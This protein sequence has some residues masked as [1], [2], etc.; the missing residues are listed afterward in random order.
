M[1]GEKESANRARGRRDSVKQPAPGVWLLPAHHLTIRPDTAGHFALTRF[2]QPAY[3]TACVL[4]RWMLRQQVEGNGS[5]PD[6]STKRSESLL[7]LGAVF[8][9]LTYS[10]PDQRYQPVRAKWKLRSQ[11]LSSELLFSS[12]GTEL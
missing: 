9:R 11:P 6:S 7:S 4:F 10:H 3:S 5:C 2:V 8:T 12:W 1:T